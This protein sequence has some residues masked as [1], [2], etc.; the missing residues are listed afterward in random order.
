MEKEA[1]PLKAFSIEE[2][3]NAIATAISSLTNTEVKADVVLF[4]KSDFDP[5]VSISGKEKFELSL[6]LKVGVSYT[7]GLEKNEDGSFKL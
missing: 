7:H 1:K 6:T 4:K 3:E 5:L 2:I